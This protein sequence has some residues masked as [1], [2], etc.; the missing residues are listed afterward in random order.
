LTV[1]HLQA[2]KKARLLRTIRFL[3]TFAVLETLVYAGERSRL[4]LRV[5]VPCPD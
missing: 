2:A 3:Q 4:V 5:A 1:Y